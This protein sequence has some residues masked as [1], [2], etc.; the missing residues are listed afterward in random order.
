MKPTRVAYLEQQHAALQIQCHLCSFFLS[1]QLC[2]QTLHIVAKPIQHQFT[3]VH[4]FNIGDDVF[5]T[6]P[7]VWQKMDDI[8]CSTYWCASKRNLAFQS[9]SS[10][11]PSNYSTMLMRRVLF[12]A[13]SLY[14]P[15][16]ALLTFMFLL[17]LGRPNN[18]WTIS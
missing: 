15:P 17:L 5:K 11:A 6:M 1:S 10:T 3:P 16:S 7:E 12:L 13:V 8:E 2:L 4:F 9:S 14:K 18:Q